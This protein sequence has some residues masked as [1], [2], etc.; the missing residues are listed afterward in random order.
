[1][2]KRID[3]YWTAQAQEDLRQIRAFIARD[4]PLTASAFV[5]RLRLSV[6]RLRT[7]PQSG[8]V[9]PEIGKSEIREVVRGNYRVIYR[10]QSDRVEI[11]T[12]F[13]G[14]RLLD[15]TEF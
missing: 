8:Q 12:I 11:L 14:A 1:M 5:P 3:L 15:E 9:V 6:E 10:V 4:A 13:H 2:T 7:F